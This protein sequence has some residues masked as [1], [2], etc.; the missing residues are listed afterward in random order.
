LDDFDDPAGFRLDRRNV[1]ADHH[2]AVGA[3]FKHLGNGG[4]RRIEDLEILR[5]RYASRSS[6][7][8]VVERVDPVVSTEVLN[9]LRKMNT[10]PL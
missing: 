6:I 2:I 10:G 3:Q 7:L 5:Q 1:I 9:L 8:V 4:L